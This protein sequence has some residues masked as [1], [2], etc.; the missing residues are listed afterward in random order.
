MT[1]VQSFKGEEVYIITLFMRELNFI[2]IFHS[3]YKEHVCFNG[4]N[5]LTAFNG[6]FKLI[7]SLGDVSCTLCILYSY[8][9]MK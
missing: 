7:V 8:I 3:K 1:P 5:I 6:F 2:D 9:P 4:P